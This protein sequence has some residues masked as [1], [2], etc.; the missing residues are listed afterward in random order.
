MLRAAQKI[1]ALGATGVPPVDLHVSTR[2]PNTHMCKL[3]ESF[4]AQ[5]VHRFSCT[6][7]RH[8]CTVDLVMVCRTDSDYGLGLARSL[9][10]VSVVVARTP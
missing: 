9:S 7:N 6:D 3:Q 4:P 1:L 8:H 10:L 2:V 5:C